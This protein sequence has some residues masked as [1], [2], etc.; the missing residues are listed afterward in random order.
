MPN[1]SGSKRIFHWRY[2]SEVISLFAP[3]ELVYQFSKTPLAQRGL[4]RVVMNHDAN[5]SLRVFFLQI[6]DY[7]RVQRT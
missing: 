3:V 7:Q 5:F 2:Y 4:R 6:L 1:W